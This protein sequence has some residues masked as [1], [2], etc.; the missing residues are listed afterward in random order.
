ML[1]HDIKHIEH[2]KIA[3]TA[4]PIYMYINLITKF[5]KFQTKL[6]FNLHIVFFV[7]SNFS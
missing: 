6:A 7:V 1:K 5:R 3:I 2:L 4:R